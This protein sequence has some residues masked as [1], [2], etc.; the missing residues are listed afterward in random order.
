LMRLVEELR[1]C[2]AVQGTNTTVIC[3]EV[4][5]RGTVYWTRTD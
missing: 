4:E 5:V 2:G 3:R 1:A